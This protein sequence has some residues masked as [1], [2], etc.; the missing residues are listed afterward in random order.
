M[1][2][3]LPGCLPIASRKAS[4]SRRLTFGGRAFRLWQFGLRYSRA[5]AFGIALEQRG[6]L[7]ITQ[8][9]DRDHP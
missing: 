1:T 5:D 2:A 4:F 7:T 8:T 3:V 9:P 6:L